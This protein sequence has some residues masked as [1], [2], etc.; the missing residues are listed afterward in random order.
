MRGAVTVDGVPFTNKD[1]VYTSVHTFTQTRVLSAWWCGGGGASS[2][3]E[4]ANQSLP[5]PRTN[6]HPCPWGPCVPSHGLRSQDHRD[7]GHWQLSLSRAGSG[8]ESSWSKIKSPTIYCSVQLILDS[9]SSLG[10]WG[11]GQG[12]NFIDTFLK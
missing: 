8:G 9:E 7:A 12:A 5:R 4:H 1:T 2:G 11:S 6:V 3:L 10:E